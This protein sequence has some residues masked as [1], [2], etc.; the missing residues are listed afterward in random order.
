MHEYRVVI[1]V[2]ACNNVLC[3]KTDFL[4]FVE[5]CW[6]LRSLNPVYIIGKKKDKK[7]C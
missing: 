3:A 6:M 7:R 1:E 4:D 5:F 2:C